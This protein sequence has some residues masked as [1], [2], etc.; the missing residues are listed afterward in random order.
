MDIVTILLNLL[1]EPPERSKSHSPG[2]T[3]VPVTSSGDLNS[4]TLQEL[5]IICLFSV[6][7][8]YIILL[9]AYHRMRDMAGSNQIRIQP[10][11]N[12]MLSRAVL[13]FRSIGKLMGC[14]YLM[15]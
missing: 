11:S 2:M 12:L 14:E 15:W 8:F 9:V 13:G 1:Y 6:G 4:D 5:S 7:K 10:R 3:I